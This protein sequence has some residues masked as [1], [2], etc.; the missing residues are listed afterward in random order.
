ME[1]SDHVV[2]LGGPTLFD[3]ELSDNGVLR[4]KQCVGNFC[5]GKIQTT[6]CCEINPAGRKHVEHFGECAGS[7]MLLFFFE[8]L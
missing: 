1:L 5:F 2:P 3:K 6:R 4:T 8:M 7:D